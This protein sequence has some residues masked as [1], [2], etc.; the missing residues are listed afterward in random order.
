MT[1]YTEGFSHFVTSM[2]VPVASGW[3]DGREGFAPTEKRRLSTVALAKSGQVRLENDRVGSC[4]TNA[5]T[6]KGG[7]MLY[8]R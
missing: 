6:M 8:E 4:V 1:R 7:A 3:S 2:T 5:P